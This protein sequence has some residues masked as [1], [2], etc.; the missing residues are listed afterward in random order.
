MTDREA[1]AMFYAAALQGGQGYEMDEADL[2]LKRLNARFPAPKGRTRA[3][4]REQRLWAKEQRLRVAEQR[5]RGA[6]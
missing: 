5:K 1:W 3:A 4:S 6:I 2:A